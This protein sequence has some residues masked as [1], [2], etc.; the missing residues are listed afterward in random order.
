[1][2]PALNG[3]GSG[4]HADS[5]GAC[6]VCAAAVDTLA[7]KCSACGA[8]LR[9]RVATLNFFETLYQILEQPRETFLR[10]ARSE[11]KNYV[12]TLYG[13]SGIGLAS[14]VFFFGRAADHGWQF[15]T[16][17]AGTFIGGPIVGLVLWYLVAVT[18]Q[19]VLARIGSYP[20]RFRITSAFIAFAQTPLLLVSMILVPIE[21]GVFGEVL[22]SS[23][24]GPWTL[25]PAIF[26]TLAVLHAGFVVYEAWLL[27]VS[28]PAL[29]FSRG[30]ARTATL[31]GHAVLFVMIGGLSWLVAS[32]PLG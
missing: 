22:F 18:T 10:I 24:P 32:I 27:S 19:L 14:L 26:W 28:F 23:N 20:I 17:L 1:M 3:S 4:A 13:L 15:G 5:A 8:F 12:L 25:K 31:I 21:L 16:L 11:Q 30:G 6:P 9:D 7:L 2:T 29:G